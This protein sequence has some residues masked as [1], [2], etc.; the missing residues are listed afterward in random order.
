L[1]QTAQAHISL[2]LVALIYGGNYIIAKEVMDQAYLEPLG[3]ILLRVVT[4]MILFGIVHRL[5]IREKVDRKDLFL[6]AVCGFFGVAVNQMF[7][8]S[9]L[10]LTS[11][12]NA[13]LI[14]TTTPMLVLIAS[15]FI[16]GE[17]ITSGKVV[18]IL[19]GASGAILLILY[20]KSIDLTGRAWL[21][22][23]LV[24]INASSYGIYLV[25]IK[26]LMK[27]YHP[28]TVIKWT[29]SFGFLFVIPFGFQQ[30]RD[31][32]W[33]TF[34]TNIWLAVLYVLI[35]TTF[36]TYF[37]NAFALVRVTPSIVSIYIYLQPLLAALI[38]LSVGKDSMSPIKWLA[39]ILI[40]AG[41]YLVS[42]PS[43]SSEKSG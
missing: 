31:A 30:L 9:G 25:L 13:S 37:L 10:K 14:M 7:F 33:E 16:L 18:G 43:R 36:F 22:N 28:F 34:T 17:R 11:P 38:A 5:F 12:I 42:K 40:F 21:G 35:F 1:N 2:F 27:K 6:L 8:F 29:F 24:F 4:A 26:P 23:L 39:G 32:P 20:G 19:T 3:F 41:V 15:A